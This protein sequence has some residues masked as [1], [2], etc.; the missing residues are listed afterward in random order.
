M[1]GETVALTDEDVIVSTN[2]A[3]NMAVPAD[4]IVTVGADKVVTPELKAEGLAREIV[5]R[6][7]TQRKN[8]DFNIEDRIATWYAASGDF[9]KMFNDWGEYIKSETLTTELTFGEPPADLF[10]FKNL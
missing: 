4:K 8:G 6:I 3:E 2:A 10:L 5:R 9:E 7:Q 1:N